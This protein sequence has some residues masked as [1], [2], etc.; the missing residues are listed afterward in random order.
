MQFRLSVFPEVVKTP[1]TAQDKSFMK[2]DKE[3]AKNGPRRKFMLSESLSL[4]SLGQTAIFVYLILR[5]FLS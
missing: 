4:L 5:G 3:E 1:A 2:L